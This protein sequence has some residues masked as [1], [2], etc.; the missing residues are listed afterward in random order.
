[1]DTEK[2]HMSEKVS[3]VSVNVDSYDGDEREGRNDHT[4]RVLNA[5]QVQVSIT[6]IGCKDAEWTNRMPS[7]AFLN[8]GYDWHEHLC[9]YRYST[10]P[11]W[12]TQLTSGLCVLVLCDFLCKR[13]PG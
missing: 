9:C 4:K 12:A 8:R 7:P 11:W 5:R 6:G 3:A 2:A 13:R 10:R 1:M